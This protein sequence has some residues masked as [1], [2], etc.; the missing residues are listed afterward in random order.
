M[1]RVLQNIK[2]CS[3]MKDAGQLSH[4]IFVTGMIARSNEQLG[5][6]TTLKKFKLHESYCQY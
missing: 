1:V 2:Q 6:T 3:K 4:K 5:E